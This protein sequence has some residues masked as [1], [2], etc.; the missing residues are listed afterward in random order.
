[1]N[2]PVPRIPKLSIVTPVFNEEATLDAYA[3]RVTE[4]LADRSGCDVQV[5]L[6]DDGSRDASWEKIQALCGRDARFRGLRLSRNFGAHVALAAGLHEATG[7]A[8]AILACDL[9]DPPEVVL[10]FLEE[11]KQGAQIVWGKRRTRSDAAWRIWASH[12]F[13]DLTRRYAM[14]SG[15]RFTT[16]SFLLMDRKVVECYRQF[17]ER[18]RVTFALVAWTGFQQ[19][20]VEYD[21][22]ARIAGQSAWKL[23]HLVR[24]AYDTFLGFSKVPFGIMTAL[25]ATMFALSIPFCLYLLLC[26]VLGNPQAGW[27]SL[28]MA[29]VMLF[30]LQFM[31][32]SVLGEYLSRIYSESV[33]RP[34]YFLSDDTREQQEPHRAAA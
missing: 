26:Y 1:M 19:A 10:Q 7:D 29:L 22:Q 25:G 17:H 13:E 21:R 15:S 32:M 3:G 4:V 16:G 12:A 5:L 11:W 6:V 34:L 9:Q 14:P 27:T 8:V 23:K 24:T 31:F 20:V 33:G 30:G 28:M 18:Q 2:R